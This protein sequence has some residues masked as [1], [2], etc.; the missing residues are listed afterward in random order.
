[1][2]TSYF[3][4]A[5]YKFT[6]LDAQQL[7]LLKAQL[8]ERAAELGVEGL[9]LLSLE[10]CNATIAGNEQA[11]SSFRSFVEQELKFGVLECKQ[12]RSERRPFR[13]FKVDLR[14]ELITTNEKLPQPQ[15]NERYLSP[16]EWHKM[17]SSD[18]EN[19]VILDTRNRYETKLGMFKG[20]VDPEIDRFSD[21][22]SYVE[23]QRNSGELSVDKKILMY[24]TGGIRCEKAALEMQARGFREVY[25][26]TGGILK[27]LE[28]Y[29]NQLF[30]GECFVFDH[31]VAVDQTLAPSSRWH[32]CP[33][34]GDPADQPLACARCGETT[35]VCERCHADELRRSCS[36]NCSHHLG[37][38]RVRARAA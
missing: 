37:L 33:H 21:F 8:E 10:G 15:V 5:F 30:D 27:Y 9:F 29:P 26:L 3:V 6:P 32:L 12:S 38:Q 13:R 7:P 11:I 19:C 16:S 20:A 23:R 14:R 18:A 1:M 22:A 2:N 34:C 36:K 4:I 24:C 25:Q 17:I 31:R 28:E 35:V